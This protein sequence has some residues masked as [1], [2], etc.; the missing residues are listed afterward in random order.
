MRSP[1]FA[2]AERSPDLRL[3]D[4]ALPGPTVTAEVNLTSDATDS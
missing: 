1:G 2:P 3:S 4:D